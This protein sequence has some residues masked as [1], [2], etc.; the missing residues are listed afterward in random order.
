MPYLFAVKLHTD[1][2]WSAAPKTHTMLKS[3]IYVEASQAAN[4]PLTFVGTFVLCVRWMNPHTITYV[5]R[6][7][8]CAWAS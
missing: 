3:N 5:K 4:L 1:V 2:C 6:E 8:I 7:N